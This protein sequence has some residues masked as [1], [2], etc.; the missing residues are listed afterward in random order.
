MRIIDNRTKTVCFE[1][2]E[3]GD[4][5]TD[6]NN[7]LYMRVIIPDSECNAVRL[8]TGRSFCFESTEVVSPV[9]AELTIN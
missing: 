2:L 3:Y 1:K 7:D 9:N 8:G 5:F 6:E 4:C